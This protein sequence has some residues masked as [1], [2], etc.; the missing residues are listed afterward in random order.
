MKWP[1]LNL[2]KLNQLKKELH[3]I[4]WEEMNIIQYR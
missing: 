3:N 4:K 2:F 1:V